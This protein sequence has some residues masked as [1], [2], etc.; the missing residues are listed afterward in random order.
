[1][2]AYGGT[3]GLC[4]IA[5]IR[6]EGVFRYGFF[7]VPGPSLIRKWPGTGVAVLLLIEHARSPMVCL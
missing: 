3:G 5:G 7:S 4:G 6:V 2:A 1:M